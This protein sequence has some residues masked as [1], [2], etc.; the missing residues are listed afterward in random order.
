[1]GEGIFIMEEDDYNLILN[2]ENETLQY[3]IK[4]KQLREIIEQIGYERIRQFK[5]TKKGDGHV[6]RK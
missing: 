6:K 5:M 3:I 4:L 1:M 2:T